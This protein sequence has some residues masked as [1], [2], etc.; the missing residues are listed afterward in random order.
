MITS[1][2]VLTGYDNTA[3]AHF[4]PTT[5]LWCK[6]TDRIPMLQSTGFGQSIILFS[7]PNL[8]VFQVVLSFMFPH[9]N[10]VWI[11]LLPSTWPIGKKVKCT[12]VQALRLCKGRTAHMGSRCIALLFLDH[13]TRRGWGVSVT[14]QPLFTPRKD[15]VPIVQEAGWAPHPH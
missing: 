1:D 2:S 14:S 6:T 12:L 15:P 8:G 3:H 13:S 9:Q 5:F 10:P 7:H 11:S 4:S